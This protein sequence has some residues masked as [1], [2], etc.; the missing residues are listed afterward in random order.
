M[1]DFDVLNDAIAKAFDP[2]RPGFYANIFYIS[3][4]VND[5]R[6]AFGT[7]KPNPDDASMLMVD[8]FDLSVTMPHS[9]ARELAAKIVEIL[10]GSK[11]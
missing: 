1:P 9:I 5:L 6:V 2:N 11:T 4:T 3:G 10:E 7:I 8:K